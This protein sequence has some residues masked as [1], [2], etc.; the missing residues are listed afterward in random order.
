MTRKK[1]FFMFGGETVNGTPG[2]DRFDCF[3]CGGL[4]TFRGVITTLDESDSGQS[5]NWI[6]PDC[7]LSD[8]RA[9][10][11]RIREQR[12]PAILKEF[13]RVI[14]KLRAGKKLTDD[15]DFFVGNP[16]DYGDLDNPVCVDAD[17]MNG[18]IADLEPY[19]DFTRFGNYAIARAIAAAS[20]ELD[21]GKAKGKVA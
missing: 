14:G 8:P 12:L 20:R 18:I 13:D 2:R 9:V 3:F 19:D 10:I 1:L 21:N 7:V 4:F 5:G 16:C 6:C 17:T 11:R 15:E